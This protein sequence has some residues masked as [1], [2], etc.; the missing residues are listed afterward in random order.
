MRGAGGTRRPRSPIRGVVARRTLLAVFLL[1]PLTLPS[2]V[3]A[4][5]TGIAGTVVNGT[6]GGKVEDLEVTLHRYSGDT[7]VGTW[8]AT[9]ND[10]GAFSFPGLAADPTS[11]Y[12][13]TAR[14]VDVEYGTDPL[15]F[16]AGETRSVTL[17]VYETTTSP[18][19]VTIARWIVWVDRE[20]E[21]AAVQHDL[22]FANSAEKAYTGTEAVGEGQRAVIRIPLAPGAR[23]FQYLGTFMECCGLVEGDTF[24]HTKPVLPGRSQATLRYSTGRLS[25]LSFPVQYPT[26]SFTLLVPAGVDVTSDGLTTSG[27]TEDRGTTYRVFTATDLAAGD[28]IRVS[29]T[30]LERHPRSSLVLLLLTIAGVAVVAAL[31]LWLSARRRVDR[32]PAGRRTGRDR[33][34]SRRA[35]PAQQSL[36]RRDAKPLER[37][38]AARASRLPTPTNGERG[39]PPPEE[40]EEDEVAVLVEEIAALDLSFE[41]GVLDERTYRRLRTATKGRLLRLRSGGDDEVLT[42]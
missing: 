25:S 14:Y 35:G 29:L 4:A 18:D 10:E 39:R 11:S 36:G 42:R 1:V 20:G 5:D 38:R 28:T 6:D 19:R 16:T 15:Q 24:V 33:V 32:R 40:P 2:A 3:L 8:T 26:K 27:D 34:G 13:L 12:R 9:T 41:R 17:K 31:A 21:G 22:D 30:G 23:D 37:Q 7:E